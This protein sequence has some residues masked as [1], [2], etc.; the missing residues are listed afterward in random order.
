MRVQELNEN[1]L[2]EL[3]ERY[4]IEKNENVSYGELADINNLV[5]NE[6]IFREYEHI[7]FVEEDF[8]SK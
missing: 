8:F 2:E 7:N 3:K 6:E 5:S 4:Y 1:Q